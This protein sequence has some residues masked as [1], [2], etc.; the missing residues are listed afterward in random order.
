[1]KF[2]AALA[3]SW[4]F[5]KTGD[6]DRLERDFCGIFDRHKP[7]AFDRDVCLG[8]NSTNTLI[9]ACDLGDGRRAA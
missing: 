6:E 1:M 2:C 8:C 9:W 4:R 7:Q 3:A 5:M